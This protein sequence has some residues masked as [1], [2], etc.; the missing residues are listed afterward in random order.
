MSEK[1][2]VDSDRVFGLQKEYSEKAHIAMDNNDEQLFEALLKANSSQ[3]KKFIEEVLKRKSSTDSFIVGEVFQHRNSKPVFQYFGDNFKNW[4]WE[5]AKTRGISIN[6]FGQ[7][8]L[9]DYVLPKDMND[10][11]IVNANSFTSMTEDQFWAMLFLLIIIPKFG[12]KILKYELRKDK[13]YILNVKLTS[14]KVVPV[15]VFCAGTVWNFDAF[16]FDIGDDWVAGNV[17]LFPVAG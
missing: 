12:K 7:N 13:T 1:I 9:K 8:I 15:R 10:T 17:F 3:K 16:T 14:G 11:A 2:V 5:P 6:A 4:L